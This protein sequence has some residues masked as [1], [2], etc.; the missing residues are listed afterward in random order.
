MG[1]RIAVAVLVLLFVLTILT[2][3]SAGMSAVPAARSVRAGSVRTRTFYGGGTS[4]WGSGG[5]GSGK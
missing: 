3:Y 5:F 1:Y 2:A 4:S